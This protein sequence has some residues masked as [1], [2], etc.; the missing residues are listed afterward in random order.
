[1]KQFLLFV[2][3]FFITQSAL[4]AADP[5]STPTHPTS[6]TTATPIKIGMSVSL[7]G[8][9]AL[10]GKSIR[11]GVS[12]YFNKIN[13]A[14]GVDGHPL[15]LI[16]LDDAYTPEQ[17]IQNIR[18]LIKNDHVIAIVG[19]NGSASAIASVPVV[20]A[21][22]VLL[23][24]A[25][26]GTDVLHKMPPDRYVINLRVSYKQEVDAMVNGLLSIGIKP[27]QFAFLAQNDEFGTTIYQSAIQVLKSG[28]AKADS[29][30]YSQFPRNTVNVEDSIAQILNN[31]SKT[32]RAFI[33]GGTVSAN[34][35]IIKLAQPNFPNAYFVGF[36]GL[37][38]PTELNNSVE[39]KVLLSQAVPYFTKSNLPALQ[40]YL[41]DVKKYGGK[42]AKTNIISFQ[43]YLT[44][45][46]FV[47]GLKQAVLNGRLTREGIID[48]FESMHDIDIGIGIKI[49]FDKNHHQA[50]DTIWP[51]IYKGGD[52]V[53]LTW[54]GLTH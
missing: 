9:N 43:A 44:A 28:Y 14:G 42:D 3:V 18:Q 51:G 30:P 23:F 21:E 50:L 8:Q 47:V 24:G 1:M 5:N 45:K 20:N 54:S 16:A 53:P 29:L 26:P 52:F 17:A 36:A 19:D 22:K 48:T 15:E 2:I 7:T 31:S 12:I 27:E 11:Q 41:A 39:G 34:E 40:E 4:V 13:A 32:I 35:K 6:S 38:E 49:H 10:S 25:Y 37:I 46:L 33:L